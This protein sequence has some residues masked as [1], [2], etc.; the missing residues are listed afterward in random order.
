[1]GRSFDVSAYPNASKKEGAHQHIRQMMGMTLMRQPS[2]RRKSIPVAV[3]TPGVVSRP[4]G[5]A[6]AR[7]GTYYCTSVAGPVIV[8]CRVAVIIII[9]VWR[10]ISCWII[11]GVIRS[12]VRSVCTSAQKTCNKASAKDR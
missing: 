1:L 11:S 7:P 8:R 6:I 5:V 4:V 9:G 2:A 10:V 3:N 12:D